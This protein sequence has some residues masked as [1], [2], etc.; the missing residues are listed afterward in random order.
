VLEKNIVHVLMRDLQCPADHAVREATSLR[1]RIMHLYAR[2][3][4]QVAARSDAPVGRYSYDIGHLVRGNLLWSERT[5]RY[6]IPAVP[7]ASLDYTDS[8][9][10]IDPAPVPLPAISWWWDLL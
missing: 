10:D 6:Q 8:P 2:L 9:D 5:V 7:S 4:D 3:R 1:N